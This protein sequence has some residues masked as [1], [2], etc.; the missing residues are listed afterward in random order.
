M[1]PA[2]YVAEDGLVRHQWGG[3]VFGP[4]KARCPSVRECQDREMG[5]GGLVR[6]CVGDGIGGFGGEMRKGDN[7]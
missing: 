1:A 5:L 7:I 2:A 4:V 3:E 6:V